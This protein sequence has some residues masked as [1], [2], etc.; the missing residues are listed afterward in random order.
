M[1]SSKKTLKER[2]ADSDRRIINSAIRNFGIRGYS[3]CTVSHIAKDARVTSGLVIQRFESKENLLYKAYEDALSSYY[4]DDEYGK[5]IYQY[6]EKVINN[7]KNLK[8]TYPEKFQFLK[9][10]I[11][12]ADLPEN[13]LQVKRKLFE[14]RNIC[15]YLNDAQ[16]KGIIAKGDVFYLY[17][18]FLS[19]VYSQIEICDKNGLEYPDNSFFVRIFQVNDEDMMTAFNKKEEIFNALRKAYKRLIAISIADNTASLLEG[20]EAEILQRGKDARKTIEK[21]I[22]EQVE[23]SDQQKMFDFYNFDTLDERMGNK[24][25]IVRNCALKGN[26]EAF[27]LLVPMKRDEKGRI[28]EVLSGLQIVEE[29]YK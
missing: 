21:S 4:A 22:M 7:I 15:G 24:K 28:I 26:R 13:N 6:F 2:R 27:A 9:T 14:A 1:E 3:N 16:Q 11:A 17:Q 23:P 20:N 12:T 19:Q 10:V 5:N 29:S 18:V 25:I 8:K